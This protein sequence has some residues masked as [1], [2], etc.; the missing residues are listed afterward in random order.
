MSVYPSVGRDWNHE[1][2]GFWQPPRSKAVRPNLPGPFWNHPLA[3]TAELE[4]SVGRNRR[5]LLRLQPTVAHGIISG[6]APAAS[7]ARKRLCKSLDRS[8][9]SLEGRV[10]DRHQAV[11][12][13]WRKQLPLRHGQEPSDGRALLEASA[14]RNGHRMGGVTTCRRIDLN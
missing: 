8:A 14:G 4:A 9:I 13:Q 7:E 1:L 6:H 11:G 2:A 10:S 12:G 3:E 5:T